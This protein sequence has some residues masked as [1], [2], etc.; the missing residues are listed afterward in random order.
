MRFVS[1]LSLSKSGRK[2]NETC[3]GLILSIPRNNKS[4]IIKANQMRDLSLTI[5]LHENN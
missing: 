4:T 3:K 2:L 5:I 1:K